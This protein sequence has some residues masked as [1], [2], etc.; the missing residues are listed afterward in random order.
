M[1][2]EMAVQ[3]PI[4]E[5]VGRQDHQ[6][7]D[8]QPGEHIGI[9][10]LAAPE[11]RVVHVLHQRSDAE[12]EQHEG[13]EEGRT[14]ERPL[15]RRTG[16]AERRCGDDQ[17]VG[18]FEG[19]ALLAQSADQ[20]QGQHDGADDQRQQQIA[21]YRLIFHRVHVRRVRTS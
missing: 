14:A 9:D 20:I 21:E 8:V 16:H 12:E 3:H 6:Y 17:E 7:Y 19:G 2:L 5:F 18:D 13:V 11:G 1:H 15:P 4:G 10:D